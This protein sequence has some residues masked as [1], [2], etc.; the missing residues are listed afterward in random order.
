MSRRMAKKDTNGASQHE[1]TDQELEWL[2]ENPDAKTG[3]QLVA[4]PPAARRNPYGHRHKPSIDHRLGNESSGLSSRHIDSPEKSEP[5]PVSNHAHSV[6]SNRGVNGVWT[7]DHAPN[8]TVHLKMGLQENFEE[9]FEQFAYFRRLGD[10]VSARKY[11]AE[12]LQDHLDKPYV[13][14]LYAEM[15]LE[16]GDYNTLTQLDDDIIFRE[17]Q[18]KADDHEELLLRS[19]W[20]L[21]H[22]HVT[23]Y[24]FNIPK[25]RYSI[26]DAL[27]GLN[28]LYTTTRPKERSIG[29]TEINLLAIAYRSYGHAVSVKAREQIATGLRLFGSGFHKRLYNDLLREGRIWDLHDIVIARIAHQSPVDITRDFSSAQS[30]QER[31]GN[32]VADWSKLPKEYDKSTT[33]ALL[34]ILVSFVPS[35]SD[36]S[37]LPDE[38]C[39]IILNYATKL[40]FSLMEND[41]DSTRTRPFIRWMLAKARNATKKGPKYRMTQKEYLGSWPGVVWFAYSHLLPLYVPAKFE[42]PGWGASNATA[43]LKGPVQVVVKTSR[44][45]GDYATEAEALQELIKLSTN[46]SNEFEDLCNLQK[47]IQGDDYRYSQTLVSKYLVANSD[48]ARTVLKKQIT[49]QSSIPGFFELLDP[50]QEWSL[51][52]I[53]HALEGEGPVAEL[54]L[55]EADRVLKDIYEDEVGRKVDG[56]L[57]KYICREVPQVGQRVFGKTG[58]DLDQWFD[59][60]EEIYTPRKDTDT[61]NTAEESGTNDTGHSNNVGIKQVRFDVK[62]GAAAGEAPTIN[63]KDIRR[64]AYLEGKLDAMQREV[65]RRMDSMDAERQ[66]RQRPFHARLLSGRSDETDVRNFSPPLSPPSRPLLLPSTESSERSR[67]SESG[68]EESRSEDEDHGKFGIID[69]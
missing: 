31:L 43:E 23:A 33:L 34:D 20:E 24:K 47:S 42:N 18:N 4:T 21:I 15:L 17:R 19:Y 10:F 59:E 51:R 53:Q 14:V 55:R 69:H 38:T 60:Q 5:S 9:H 49:E 11:F 22:T 3:M 48:H 26:S 58:Y 63:I 61:R 13:L 64:Q 40:A 36:R 46:P 45:L 65:E 32:F 37:I 50:I 7:Q 16:Q 25:S 67:F 57:I 39:E 62:K 41:P 28:K 44:L 12:N 35:N 2:R 29:S 8:F 68:S 27:L 6:L 1:G 52:M 56:E 30:F 66:F 54:Y